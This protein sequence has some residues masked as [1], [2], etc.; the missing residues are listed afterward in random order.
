MKKIIV[1]ALLF[2]TAKLMAQDVT[3]QLKEASNLE[4]SLKDAQALE[5]Y[6]SILSVEPANLQVLV[7]CS[8]ICAG[9]GGRQTDKKV[10]QDFY[11]KAR[12]YADKALTANPESADA[13]Y[14]RALA[15]AK[16]AE[17]ETDNKKLVVDIKDMKTF[18]D[19]ALSINPNHGKANY[20][21]GKWN[22]Q[23]VTLS[24]TKKAAIKVLF[25]G[26]PD[27]SIEN[28]FRYLEKCKS[29][30]PYYVQNFLDLGKAYKFDNQPAKAI[31]VLNQLVK[32]PTRTSD[33]VALKA[34]GKTLLSE[35]Q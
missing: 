16:L 11:E 15:A 32:L 21:L 18:A 22:F 1:I 23:M 19:K 4:R 3:V 31:D 27:A 34:E 26:V 24:W 12:E 9:I 33:D 5:K 13:N 7:R 2:A 29:V 30:E 10:K 20:V 8:E 17:V 6:Q 25:G 14:V 35:M 28:A